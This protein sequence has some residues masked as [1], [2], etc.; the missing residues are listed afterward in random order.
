MDDDNFVAEALVALADRAPSEPPALAASVERR[1]VHRRRA[2]QA[3]M[4]AT[5]RCVR[6]ERRQRTRRR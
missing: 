6:A 2:R 3:A 5:R 4:A 1:F